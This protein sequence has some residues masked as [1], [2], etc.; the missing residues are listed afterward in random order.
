MGL[1]ASIA[2]AVLAAVETPTGRGGRVSNSF[3]TVEGEGVCVA[4]DGRI[5]FSG[6]ESPVSVEVTARPGWLVDGRRSLSFVRVPGESRTLLVRSATLEDEEHVPLEDC[7]FDESFTNRHV[8]PPAIKMAGGGDRLLLVYAHPESNVLVSASASCEVVSNGVHE[9]EHIWLPCSECGSQRVPSAETN[10]VESIP[11][12]QYW[13]ASGAGITTNSSS[14]SGYLTKGLGQKI[15]LSV[16]VTN[17]CT[18][19]IC[20]AGT[21]VV[22]DVH[23]L[24][25][26]LPDEY[27][28]LDM[29]D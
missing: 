17:V 21:N 24:Y 29:R 15:D 10:T 18:N 2:S 8:L 5:H 22:V 6:S 12:E 20:K 28:G 26:D 3:V 16:V 13:T 25:I 7:D 4:D 1:T 23:E 27:L 14:W 19:C 9:V 11:G